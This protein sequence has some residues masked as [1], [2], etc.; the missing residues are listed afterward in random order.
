MKKVVNIASLISPFVI[1]LFN[2][3]LLIID[4]DTNT[5]KSV[6]WHTPKRMRYT[7]ESAHVILSDEDVGCGSRD[8]GN[9]INMYFPQ[10]VSVNYQ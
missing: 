7:R 3:L 6:G 1:I 2:D 9:L 5:D 4:S 8:K 10:A